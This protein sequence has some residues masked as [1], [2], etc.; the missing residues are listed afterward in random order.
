M[1]STTSSAVKGLGSAATDHRSEKARR[2]AA[3]CSMLIG[4]V[5]VALSALVHLHLWQI[6]YKQIPTIGPLF[7]IQV[8]AGFLLAAVVAGS[9]RILPAFAAMAFLASTIG[10]LVLSATIG[11]F[12]FHDGLSAPD[13]VSSLILEG[14]GIL[15]LAV[16]VALRRSLAGR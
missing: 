3:L 2:V 5:L 4:A 11:I 14:A 12:N 8:I 10:G 16:A 7:L 9:R 13:A 15:V 1:V 6:G